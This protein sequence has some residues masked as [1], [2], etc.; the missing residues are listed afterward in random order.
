[1]KQ[2]LLMI[3]AV[4]VVGCGTTSWVSDP[5]DLNNVKIEKKIRWRI[6]KPTSRRGGT[7]LVQPRLLRLCAG[8]E[9][10]GEEEAGEGD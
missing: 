1:M 6:G 10:R 5:S 4:A 2:I 9:V 8:Q 3:A 7:H